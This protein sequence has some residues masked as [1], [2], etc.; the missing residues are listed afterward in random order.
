[1]SKTKVVA[2]RKGY[3]PRIYINPNAAKLK[4]L[5]KKGIVLVN[6]NM[7]SVRGLPLAHTYPDVEHNLIRPLPLKQRV[8][9]SS[10]SNVAKTPTTTDKIASLE[11]RLKRRTHIL[12]LAYASCAVSIGL[13]IDN[14]GVEWLLKMI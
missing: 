4:Y 10:L 7:G 3:L 13:F 5:R 14:G 12:I 9:E 8:E 6:P 11:K 1:M 2:Y